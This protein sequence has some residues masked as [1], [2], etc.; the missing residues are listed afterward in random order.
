MRMDQAVMSEAGLA[1][2]NVLFLARMLG[3][4]I[5]HEE[6]FVGCIEYAADRQDAIGLGTAEIRDATSATQAFTAVL[7]GGEEIV[8]IQIGGQS[9]QRYREAFGKHS[10]FSRQTGVMSEGRSEEIR[11]QPDPD[12]VRV[13]LRIIE[14]NG[15]R[16]GVCE[17]IA[18]PVGDAI[19]C[20]TP[21]TRV[22]ALLV[23]GK[24]AP[25]PTNELKSVWGKS[26]SA[27]CPNA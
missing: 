10:F 4:V 19:P 1:E 22:V 24:D 14:Y 6:G 3:V 23:A 16:S 12:D 21:I 7:P 2:E 8:F 13:I 11:F 15:A 27:M 9:A 20:G 26:V 25:F 5:D 17:K 18:D